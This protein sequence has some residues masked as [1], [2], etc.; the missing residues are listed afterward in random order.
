VVDPKCPAVLEEHKWNRNECDGKE[1]EQRTGPVDAESVVHGGCEEREAC[2]KGGTH[3]IVAGEDRCDVHG[4]G[5]AEVV[6]SMISLACWPA[7]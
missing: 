6:Q 5:V 4:I 2:T 7:R 3:E 1:A